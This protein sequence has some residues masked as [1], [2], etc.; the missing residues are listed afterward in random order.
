M[1]AAWLVCL[2]SVVAASA[3]AQERIP[4]GTKVGNISLSGYD[5]S[6]R[7]DPFVSLMTPKKSVAAQNASRPRAG[8]SSLSLADVSVKG[9]VRSG[10]AVLAVL[11]GPDGKSFVAHSKDKLQDAMVKSIDAEGVVFVEQQVDAGGAVRSRDIRKPLRPTTEG[12]R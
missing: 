10:A 1:K 3:A 7:R 8:L 11:E 4:T 6:G 2:F 9:I 12:V 5:D